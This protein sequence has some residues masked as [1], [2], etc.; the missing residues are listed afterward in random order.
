MI[1]SVTY[2]VSDGQG[3]TSTATVS[4]TV[5]GTNDTPIVA[6]I[7]AQDSTGRDVINLD[8]SSFFSDAETHE[9]LTF[10]ASNLPPGLSINPTTGLITGS[11]DPNAAS[12]GPYSVTVTGTD[13]H[14]A[15]VTTSFQ[16]NVENP[17]LMVLVNDSVPSVNAGDT[18]VFS[19]N[20]ANISNRDATGVVITQ[21]LPA[22]TTFNSAASTAGWINN[23]D[24][25][26][27]YALGNVDAH[28]NGT[29]LFAVTVA[30][31]LPSGIDQTST[32][33]SIADDGSHGND[34][35]PFNNIAS[36]VTSIDARPDYRITIDDSKVL[37]YRGETLTYN[38]HVSNNGSQNGTGVVVTS[39]FPPEVLGSI[40]ASHGG[41]IN[42]LAGTITWN[43]GA[44]PAGSDVNL[45]V[46]GVIPMNAPTS[47]LNFAQYVIVTDDGS[48]GADRTPSNNAAT[49]SNFLMSFGFD[50]FGNRSQ[51]GFGMIPPSAPPLT[52]S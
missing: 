43:L 6:A 4:I 47:I 52:T 32:S 13:I 23:G 46:S 10:A 7:P 42:T 49:D 40:T 5:T 44:L 16:W 12:T 35:T 20:Y 17:D 15:S 18:V 14:G 50:S 24:G 29:I 9:P 31:T 37:V 27:S 33:S 3:G 34:L 28:D 25:T 39:Y 11:I 45:T 22:H 19:V 51:E 41:V 48:N 36:D 8:V 2:T 26:Y 1:T 38:I 21:T 30:D